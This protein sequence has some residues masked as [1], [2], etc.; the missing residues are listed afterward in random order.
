MRERSSKIMDLYGIIEKH[1]TTSYFICLRFFSL[2]VIEDA[3]HI[4]KVK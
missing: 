2:H 3:T 1:C 4:I